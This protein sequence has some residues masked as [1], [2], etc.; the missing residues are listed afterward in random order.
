MDDSEIQLAETLVEGGLLSQAV[1]DRACR[2]QERVKRP[3]AEVLVG[4]EL[5][6]QSEID[7]LIAESGGTP[8]LLDR[9]AERGEL[10]PD[11]VERLRRDQGDRSDEA[12]ARELVDRGRLGE[13]ALLKAISEL[14]N[15]PLLEQ[16]PLNLIAVL[17]QL[18]V[19]FL[20][21]RQAVLLKGEGGEFSLVLSNPADQEVQ[22]EVRERVPNTVRVVLARRAAIARAL[23]SLEKQP[24]PV[25]STEAS[26]VSSKAGYVVGCS[27]A[28]SEDATGIADYILVEAERRGASD[29]HIEPFSDRVRVRLRI[30]GELMQLA[31]YPANLARKIATRFKVL[32]DM[33]VAE[34]RRHQDGRMLIQVNGKSID[35]RASGYVTLFGENLVLRLLRRE[36][37][38]VDVS[39]IGMGQMMLADFKQYAFERQSGVVII[40]G[41]TGSGKTTTLYGCVR[42]L[43]L[44]ERK[45]I[46]VEDP[47]EY[48]VDG[49]IQCSINEKAGVCFE[50]TLRAVVRQ[51]P[52]II[53]LG[54]MRDRFSAETAVQAALTGHQVF[55]TFHTEDAV[56]A[57]VRLT[58]MGIQPFLIA[59]TVSCVLGQRLARKVC[60][61]C[62]VP[63]VPALAEA[64]RFA[65]NMRAIKNF[66][67][68]RGKGCERCSNTGYRGRIGLFE[69]LQMSETLREA[70]LGRAPVSKL[71]AICREEGLVTLAEDGLAKVLRGL[72]TFS[73]VIRW[74]PYTQD[75][76]S[77]GEILERVG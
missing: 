20:R 55:T 23:A 65:L 61:H 22:R 41:P 18:P 39:Q 8:T 30:D 57:I 2:V 48:T 46:T 76:M 7:A 53:V 10:T 77:A 40:T 67:I 13:E 69:L 50:D 14:S 12:V 11:E 51:D 33:D 28:G 54:E 37:D 74:A 16:I 72:T 27:R 59:S 68:V 29:I 49:V 52:D 75:M 3:L 42:R 47:A 5:I 26:D 66:E 71:R 17:P 24:Q 44:P 25:T 4:L 9:L 58:D 1:I 15:I 38:L 45:I 36:T 64:Q 21:Q 31:D 34:H 73:E 62:K 56:G 19:P 60:D 70:M 6:S 63:Y 35:V 43:N 32:T